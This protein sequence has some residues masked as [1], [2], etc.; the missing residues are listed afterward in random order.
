MR[1]GPKM[2]LIAKDGINQEIWQKL[3]QMDFFWIC[4][5]IKELI[6]TSGGENIPPVPIETQI[7]SVE[8][9]VLEK[10]SQS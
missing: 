6:I 5:R 3:I 1:P 10:I 4:G 9:S 2:S 8:T 7:K